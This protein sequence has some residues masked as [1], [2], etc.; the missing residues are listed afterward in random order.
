MRSGLFFR[1][2]FSTKTAEA[3]ESKEMSLIIGTQYK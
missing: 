1:V 3:I 2:I